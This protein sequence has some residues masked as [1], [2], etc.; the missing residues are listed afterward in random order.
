MHSLNCLVYGMWTA[1]Q[2]SREKSLQEIKDLKEKKIPEAKEKLLREETKHSEL[3]ENYKHWS[4]IE[5]DLQKKVEEL[6][7]KKDMKV[8]CKKHGDNIS[9]QCV[10]DK[11][12]ELHCISNIPSFQASP[13]LITDLL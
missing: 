3:L 5:K 1:P 11:E 7:A 13:T 6:Q 4:K 10:P 12:C 2:N 9:D 8:V